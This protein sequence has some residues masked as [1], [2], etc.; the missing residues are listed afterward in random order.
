MILYQP[1]TLSVCFSTNRT[2]ALT[3]N[4]ADMN[5]ATKPTEMLSKLSGVRI[6]AF[7]YKSKIAAPN[8]VGIARKKENSV[9]AFLESPANSPPTMVAPERDVPGIIAIH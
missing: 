8:I 4:S 5:A 9:A 6:S 2:K 1:K 3:T 7:R